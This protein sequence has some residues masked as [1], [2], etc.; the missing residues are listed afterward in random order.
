VSRAVAVNPDR[1]AKLKGV[2]HVP[3]RDIP[4]VG[5]FSVLQDPTG[6]A[7]AIISFPT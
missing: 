5:R 1:A 7:F 4:K 6:G 3:A 2:V